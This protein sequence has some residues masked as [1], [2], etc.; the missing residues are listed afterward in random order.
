MLVEEVI[1]ARPPSNVNGIGSWNSSLTPP[2]RTSGSSQP[3]N[4]VPAFPAQSPVKMGRQRRRPG[5]RSK[6]LVV[7]LLGRE[8]PDRI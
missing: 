3:R 5:H 6:P 2:D 8:R 7:L 4:V 1:S